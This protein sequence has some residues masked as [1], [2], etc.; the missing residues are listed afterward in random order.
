MKSLPVIPNFDV[1]KD[2]TACRGMSLPMMTIEQLPTQGG[3]EAL[4][5][6]VVITVGAPTHAGCDLMRRQQLTI[7]GGRVLHPAIRVMQQS[8]LWLTARQGHAQSSHTQFGRQRLAH[9][10]THHHAT[11]QIQQDGQIQPTFGGAH[12]GNVTAPSPIRTAAFFNAEAALQQITSHAVSMPRVS[13]L[14]APAARRTCAQTSFPHQ[15]GNAMT[16]ANQTRRSHFAMH[17]GTA[18]GLP[19]GLMNRPNDRAQNFIVLGAAAWHPALRR[20]EAGPT[21][22]QHAT[23]QPHREL[24]PVTSDAGVL[25]HRSFAKY[26]AAFFKKSRSWVTSSS[27]LRKRRTSCSGLATL[28]FPGNTSVSVSSLASTCCFQWR[29]ISQRIPSCSATLTAELPFCTRP[30]ASNL[31]S[32]VYFRFAVMNTSSRTVSF[33]VFLGVHKIRAGPKPY[34]PRNHTKLHEGTRNRCFCAKP[35]SNVR[36]V[37]TAH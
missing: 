20:I 24:L 23:H 28:P 9:G 27:S 30:T 19:A 17:P 2:G 33:R 25:H 11:A 21:N 1:F 26:A 13:R 15:A 12:I 10:P 22:S 7:F 14:G 31:N 6:R 37:S 4:S 36:T 29:S 32:R 34:D 18:V 16:T 5:H 3:K 8:R 35:P